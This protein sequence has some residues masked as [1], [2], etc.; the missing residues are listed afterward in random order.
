MNKTTYNVFDVAQ[1]FLSKPMEISNKKLQKLVYYAYCWYITFFNEDASNIENRLFEN[2]F[3]A[4][5]HG[6][7]YPDLYHQYKEYGSLPIPQYKGEL[8]KFSADEEDVLQ[9]VLD[10]YGKY[11]GNE[12]E[13]ICHQESPWIKARGNTPS[14]VAS[15]NRIDDREIF[16]CFSA[17][18]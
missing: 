4:W 3:E 14:N 12:L 7:V 16:E 1:W 13:N 11:N 6:A 10:V 5:I 9:Q 2:K 17:R 18:L 8:K 15:T